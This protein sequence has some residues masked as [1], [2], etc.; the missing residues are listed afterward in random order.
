MAARVASPCHG[1]VH[2]TAF[3][4][5]KPGSLRFDARE[6]DYLGP[7]HPPPDLYAVHRWRGPSLPI[8]FAL[9]IKTAS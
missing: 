4:E 2:G 9:V 8:G 1:A 6:L 5:R 7:F 3:M